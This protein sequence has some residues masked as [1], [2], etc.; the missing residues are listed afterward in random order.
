M[1]VTGLGASTDVRDAIA[2][3]TGVPLSL[4]ARGSQAGGYRQRGEAVVEV[5][6]ALGDDPL[7]RLLVAG[8]LAGCWGTPWRWERAPSRLR[9]LVPRSLW[10]SPRLSTTSGHRT[11]P[12]D[13]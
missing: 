9:C 6:T 10:E 8:A 5:L 12:P 4:L 13:W 2:I 3:A 11:P 7:D 1:E